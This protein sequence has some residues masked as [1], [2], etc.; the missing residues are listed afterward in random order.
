MKSFEAIVSRATA[1]AREFS[2]NNDSG[3]KANNNRRWI[4]N[5]VIQSLEKVRREFLQTTY[6]YSIN[7]VVRIRGSLHQFTWY[8]K[9]EIYLNFHHTTAF[10]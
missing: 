5:Y 1:S 7:D 6:K 9:I 2:L 8:K 4:E 10:C 3:E